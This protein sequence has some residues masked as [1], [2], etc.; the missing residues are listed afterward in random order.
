MSDPEE[1]DG[2]LEEALKRRSVQSI[3]VGAALLDA[4]AISPGPLPL[5]ELSRRAGMPPSKARRY[6]IS[7]LACGLVEQHPA[8]GYYDLGPMTLRLGFAALSRMDPVRISVEA[9]AEL[10][11]ELDHTTM[12][13]V[14][15]DRG[16]IIIAW[17]DSSEILVC[18]LRVGS[19]L[20][21]TNSA[22]GKL[23]LA[24]LPRETTRALVD[25]AIEQLRESGGV[26]LAQARRDIDSMIEE[27]RPTGIGTTAEN[28]LPGLS[29]VAAPVFDSNDNIV[30]VIAEI[31]KANAADQVDGRSIRDAVVECAARVSLRLGHRWREPQE[32]PGKCKPTGQERPSRAASPRRSAKRS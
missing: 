8:T 6:L 15:S 32:G 4:L 1:L 9:A 12:V 22:S 20:P 19:L 2:E 13:A 3:K 27:V 10:S 5:R 30:A 14:W 23:F 25:K 11:R 18:N 21:L 24:F 7:F 16:P 29:A 26:S 31:H 28:L 17:F